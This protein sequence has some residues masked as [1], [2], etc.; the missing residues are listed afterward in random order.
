MS[1]TKY[2][3]QKAAAFCAYQ[4]RCTSEIREKLYEWGVNPEESE[5]I[6]A[7]LIAEKYLDEERFAKIYAGSKFRTKKWGKLKI[8]Y[9]LKQKG[10]ANTLIINGLKEIN[11]DTYYETLQGLAAQKK[12][13]MKG[14]YDRVKLYN[15]L[16]SKGFENDLVQEALKELADK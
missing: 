5:D 9:M 1:N 3:F 13:G 16:I 8:R 15:F 11:P 2:F 7:Q 10:I 12:E 4:E 6:I 14:K